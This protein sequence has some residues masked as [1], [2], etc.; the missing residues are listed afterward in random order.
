MDEDTPQWWR[1]D[2]QCV[3]GPARRIVDKGQRASS[4]FVAE[5]QGSAGRLRQLQCQVQGRSYEMSPERS[6]QAARPRSNRAWAEAQPRH[7]LN[8]GLRSQEIGI[9]QPR[10]C[11]WIPVQCLPIRLGDDVSPW[12]LLLLQPR[13]SKRVPGE[14]LL[15]LQYVEH[16]LVSR[17][18]VRE[19][20]LLTHATASLAT[21]PQGSECSLASRKSH[22][23]AELF[24]SCG[25]V[26]LTAELQSDVSAIC[27]RPAALQPSRI[28]PSEASDAR[29]SGGQTDKES[30]RWAFYGIPSSGL[31]KGADFSCDFLVSPGA[32]QAT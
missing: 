16:L 5:R 8:D 3:Q 21:R 14:C 7:A 30:S 11:H 6:R 1:R 26:L 29:L 28:L 22:T 32:I 4:M 18:P 12:H 9:H 13:S 31:I 25:L 15:P 20:A 10:A 24:M 27:R 17:W 23:V 2:R 19:A